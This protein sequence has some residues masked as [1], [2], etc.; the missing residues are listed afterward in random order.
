M[1]DL[2]S[3]PPVE[4]P[5]RRSKTYLA[6]FTT[7]ALATALLALSISR[8]N[9]ERRAVGRLPELER[10]ALYGRTMQTL[11]STCEEANRRSGLEKYCREQAE[12]VVEFP[13]CDAACSALARRHR[14]GPSR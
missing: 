3:P 1:S 11:G 10:R 8:G 9:A 2:T 6:A 14:A 4:P 7:G 5:S 13:E 12:F